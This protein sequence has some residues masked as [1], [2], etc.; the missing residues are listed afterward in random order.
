[1]QDS[2][3]PPP[4]NRLILTNADVIT[5]TATL[6][7]ASVIIEGDRI[8]EVN[9]RSYP[10]GT[11]RHETIVDVTGQLV[12]PGI[13]CLHNDAVEK[14]INPRPNTN[15]PEDFALV[16]LDR[17]LSSAGVT[18]QFHAIAFESYVA[19]QR[20]AEKG[21]RLC[22]AVHGFVQSGL[23]TIDHRILF[24]CA[25]R[26]PESLDAILACAEGSGHL[27]SMDDHAHGQ[28]QMLDLEKSWEQI[29][30]SLPEGT[31]KAEWLEDCARVVR[32]T[33]A[34]KESVRRKLAEES[35]RKNFIL[36]SHDDNSARHVDRSF[37]LGGRMSEFPVTLEAARRAHE[38][39]MS[40]GMGAPNAV[41]G[42][43]LNGNV[44]TTE[45]ATRGLLDVLLADYDAPSLLYAA[46]G[47]ARSGVDTLA[48]AIS[49]ITRNPAR[50]AGLIDRGSIEPGLRADVIVVSTAST[51]PVVTSHIV[52]G[53]LQYRVY[54]PSS[55]SGSRSSVPGALL[56]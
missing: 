56:A 15:F 47:I 8:S 49:L 55:S 28:G 38:L 16:T 44:G 13:V 33:E 35:Q 4:A 21:M 51:I 18:T 48:N 40:V 14:A 30:P 24:R 2:K 34:V 45:L 42:G 20:N 12:M 11:R 29:I 39:G 3:Q 52:A 22:G 43:S 23:G 7:P 53:A 9:L 10:V 36:V 31:S 26:Q 32:E 41:R 6:R 25:I 54:N 46:L 1:M 5:P 27:V 17:A 50:V 19:K 37:E